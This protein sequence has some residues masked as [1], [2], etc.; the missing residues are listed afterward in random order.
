[1]KLENPKLFTLELAVAARAKWRAEK[2]AV[3]L[4]NGVFDLLHAGH[5]H[6]LQSARAQGD[7]LLVAFNSDASLGAIKG[8]TRPLQSESERAFALGALSCVDGVVVFSE[9]RLT[10]EI[11]ALRPDVYCKAGDYTLEK[12]NAE[13]RSALEKI[14]AKI[15]FVPFLPGFSTTGLIA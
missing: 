2:R 3:V 7:V 15:V 5:I 14:G 1:M 11:T 13:E 8:P 10:K 12:L 4:T 9:P 6:S